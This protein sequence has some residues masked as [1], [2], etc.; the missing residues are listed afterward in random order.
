MTN[1]FI[2]QNLQTER[3]IIGACLLSAEALGFIVVIVK[4]D[5]NTINKQIL[6]D[7][8]VKNSVKNASVLKENSSISLG[9]VNTLASAKIYMT[10]TAFSCLR[11]IEQL[12]FE[13]CSGEEAKYAAENCGADWNEQAVKKAKEYLETMPFSLSGLIQQLTQF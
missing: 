12:K 3:S 9:K 13:G 10:S 11:L 1:N 4:D 2:P 7:S 6:D 5:N 8:T